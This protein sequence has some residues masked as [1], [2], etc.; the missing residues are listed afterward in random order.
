MPSTFIRNKVHRIEGLGPVLLT[1]RLIIFVFSVV[2]ETFFRVCCVPGIMLGI[3]SCSSLAF[4]SLME[5]Y[6]SGVNFPRDLGKFILHGTLIP[7]DTWL[8]EGHPR[9]SEGW[10]EI[11]VQTVI[12]APQL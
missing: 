9:H 4:R 2:T 5:T 3:S 12:L 11:P 8:W 6:I 1:S 10:R 7:F